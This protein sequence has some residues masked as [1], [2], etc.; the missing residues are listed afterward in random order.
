MFGTGAWK[1]VSN[2]PK[3]LRN[4]NRQTLDSSSD[5]CLAPSRK[6]RRNKCLRS[7]LERLPVELLQSVLSHLSLSSTAALALC[8]RHMTYLIGTKS[9]DAVGKQRSERIEFLNYLEKD[10]PGYRLCNRCLKLHRNI[11]P[12][13]MLLTQSAPEK[14]GKAKRTD[15]AYSYP[16]ININFQ[17]VQSAMNHHLFGPNH[18]LSLDFFL[19]PLPLASLGLYLQPSTRARI[20]ADE[21]V[22][23]SKYWIPRWPDKVDAYHRQQNP[24]GLCPH[25]TIYHGD[26]RMMDLIECQLHHGSEWACPS[27]RGLKICR[28]CSTELAVELHRVKAGFSVLYIT[29]WRNF[30]CGRSP[31]DVIWQEHVWQDDKNRYTS[32]NRRGRV[33]FAYESWESSV[34]MHKDHEK[35]SECLFFDSIGS[36]NSNQWGKLADWWGR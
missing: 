20:V 30:G 3:L 1:I 14:L 24:I 2:S 29:T 32:N 19:R 5:D 23:R 33:R 25:V 35:N 27:C 21:F 13:D 11:P 26:K 12:E 8:S 10:L 9:W 4:F 16:P 17:H 22:L 31:K 36:L 7:S 34:S 6:K 28:F 15:V 18:G